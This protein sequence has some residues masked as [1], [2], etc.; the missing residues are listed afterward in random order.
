[1]AT[2]ARGEG[3]IE[4][5]DENG[6]VTETVSVLFTNRALAE[7]ENATGKSTLQLLNAATMQ[8]MGVGEVAQLLAGGM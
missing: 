3:I 2:G 1:M 4:L 8:L 5:K 6:N 7:A